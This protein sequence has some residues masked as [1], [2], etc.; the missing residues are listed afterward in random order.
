MV[1]KVGAGWR[2]RACVLRREEAGAP[3]AAEDE[4]EEEEP[5]WELPEHLREYDGD[6]A[7]RKAMLSFRQAQQAAR[8]VCCL[9]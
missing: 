7:D 2:V 5:D 1:I 4:V 6:P 3:A 8:Q 9:A